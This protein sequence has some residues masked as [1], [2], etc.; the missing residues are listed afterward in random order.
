MSGGNIGRRA[1]MLSPAWPHR[2][3]R[4]YQEPRPSSFVFCKAAV[5]VNTVWAAE[6]ALGDDEIHGGPHFQP[7]APVD[8]ADPAGLR[9][10]AAQVTR[11]AL[12]PH[13]RVEQAQHQEAQVVCADGAHRASCQQAGIA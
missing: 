9:G 11:D 13:D 4:A 1:G 3:S 6:R 5:R 12:A 2:T 8:V 10:A 7:Q